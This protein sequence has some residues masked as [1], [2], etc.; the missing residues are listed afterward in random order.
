MQSSLLPLPVIDPP[1]IR[2]DDDELLDD[3]LSL[4]DELLELS[5]DDELL[6]DDELSLDDEE[7]PLDDEELLLDVPLDELPLE[8]D[9]AAMAMPPF[10]GSA[11]AM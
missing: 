8:Y 7:L 10:T 6:L 1:P 4:D 9:R 2:G 11:W 3:E 5:L